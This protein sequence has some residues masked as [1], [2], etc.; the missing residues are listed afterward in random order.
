MNKAEYDFLQSLVEDIPDEEVSD[1]KADRATPS[2][3][4]K[5]TPAKRTRSGSASSTS[6]TS[7]V[8]STPDRRCDDASTE[9]NDSADGETASCLPSATK[10]TS[11]SKSA[12]AIAALVSDDD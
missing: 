2:R 10:R 5:S 3:N 7:S 8:P 11:L 12:I 4:S 1:T 6:T 9:K